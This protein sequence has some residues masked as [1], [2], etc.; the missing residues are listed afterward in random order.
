MANGIDEQT[1]DET[2][3]DHQEI[4]VAEFFEKNKHLLGFE[5]P[6]KSIIT[7]VKE[8][9][10]NSLTWK[11]PFLVKENGETRHEKIGEFVDDLIEDNR[12]NVEVKRD[13]ELEK[14]RVKDNDLESLGFDTQSYDVDFKEVSSVFRHKVNSDIFEV[15]LEGN[16]TVELTDYHSVF[17]LRDGE[18]KSVETSSLTEDDH[19][20]L[21]NTD[22]AEGSIRDINLVEELEQLPKEKTEKIGLHN[23][24]PLI[25]KYRT[26]IEKYVDENYRVQD[27]RKC[28]RLP[29]NLVR[30]L[31]LN[32]SEIE[33]CKLGYRLGSNN[34]PAVLSFD[35]D[36]AELLGIFTAEG[37]VTGD[38]DGHEKVYFSL[39][40]HEKRLISRTEELVRRVFHLEPSTVDAHKT[41]K[42]VTIN[43]KIAGLVFEEIFGMDSKA[44]EKEVPRHLFDVS[45]ELRERFFIGYA[46]G[47]GYPTEKIIE[48]L[49][50]R[51]PLSEIEKK[52]ITVA[53]AS[54]MLSSGMRYLLSSIGIDSTHE[55]AEA[56]KRTVD[57]VETEFGSSNLLH[58]RTGETAYLNRLPAEEI[59][60]SVSAPKL[61][62][63]LDEG[64]QSRVET[65]TTLKLQ[66][67]NSITFKGDGLKIAESD[68]TA[69][70]VKSIEK[71]NYDKKWV[72][73]ISVPG[74]E[75]FMAG[76]HP[77]A[78]H[79]SLDSCEGDEILPEVHVL[80]DEVGDKKCRV[81]IRDNAVG[82]DRETIPKVFG[83]L[84]YGSKFHSLSQ[85]RGQQGIGISASAMYAQLTAGEPVT[86]YSK[87]EGEPCHKFVVR[88]DTEENEPEII[89]DEVIPEDSDQFPGDK[90]YYFEHGTTIEMNIEAQY[91]KGHHSVRNYLKHTAIMNP[92]ARVVLREP[93]GNKIEYPR[94]SNELPEKPQEIKPHL[95]GVE[96]GVVMRMVDNSSARTVS[97]F[98]Q[99]EF[100]RVG[101]TSAQEVCDEADIDDGRRPN[102]LDKDEIEELLNA[103]E[104]VKLQ[105]PPT[106]CLSPIGEDLILEGMEKELNPEFSTAI[107]RKPAVYNGKPYVVECT[108]GETEIILEDGDKKTI[109]QYVE[110]GDQRKVMGLTENG[111]LRPLDVEAKMRIPRDHDIYEVETSSGRRL[112]VTGNNELPVVKQG[113]IEWKRTDE[114]SGDDRLA[115]PASLC[116]ESTELDP[117]NLLAQ[118]DVQVVDREVVEEVTNLLSERYGSLKTAS[119]KIG[120]KCGCFRSFRKEKCTTRPSLKN[121]KEM[122]AHTDKSFE[123]YRQ[124]IGKYSLAERGMVNPKSVKIPELGTDLGYLLGMVES[125]GYLGDEYSVGFTNTSEEL[126]DEFSRL[127]KQ[128]FGVETKEAG[129]DYV[130]VDS[131]TVNRLLGELK[132]RITSSREQILEA[133]LAGFIEGDGCISTRESGEF[134]SLSF[135][136]AE[137][138]KARKVQN[139]LMQIG[140]ASRI[141]ISGKGQEAELN[142]RTIV[143]QKHKHDVMVYSL[144]E[145]QELFERIE[146][147]HPEKESRRRK[148]VDVEK[149]VRSQDRL[150][151]GE[152]LR[153]AREASGLSQTELGLAANSIRSIE[154][155]RAAVRRENLADI[156]EKLSE[157]SHRQQLE[158]MVKSDF[159]SVR[160]ESVEKLDRDDEYVYD[161]K[162]EAGNFVA[163]N[164]IMHNC[165]LA[166]G[167]DIDEEGSFDELRYANKVPLLYKK[168]ACVTTKAIE[169]VSWNRYNISQTGNRPQ[170]ELYILVHIASVWVPFTSEGKEAIAN[171]DPIRKEMK[172]A[173]QEA[174]RK[175]GRYIGRKEKKEIQEK[176]RRQ[177]T[178][179]AE[180]MGPAI[181][182]LAAK[183]DPDEIENQ[184]QKM[185]QEDYNPEQL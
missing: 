82:L 61:E 103:A 5:N 73:D 96:L 100:T 27:F 94:V 45:P 119:G 28:D 60:E 164:L 104:R 33:G 177:L 88:I 91:T 180:E 123:D 40:S 50:E 59:I 26:E 127:M 130:K 107:T 98:L 66:E 163:D 150:N 78:C 169:E 2:G 75:N 148:L 106:D 121:F 71:I 140:I 179:Y 30:E 143:T 128:L 126:L 159:R 161:L 156:C 1:I 110:S 47:D 170:G 153:K 74:H 108:V 154:K 53:T 15:D 77:I 102:T 23:V 81:E 168:S 64:R 35:S 37:S 17:V 105:S 20:V 13:G 118:E 120:I 69:V 178:S 38:R 99:E 117:L 111:K 11:T 109:E 22:W 56:E 14:L 25:G 113:E 162:T 122:V 65:A 16:R 51:K 155:G 12:E 34:I 116:T 133:W 67:E 41:A 166:W 10:D 129:E 58:V 142:G 86:V 165:G 24:K 49:V 85:S 158:K 137:P 160:V 157:S 9:V 149:P 146:L 29:F 136:T 68:L 63:N 139:V 134:K 46:A 184:I 181:A 92:Y 80:I 6:Q 87:Q 97:S 83:K 174:G 55:V 175:L 19:I 167:G 131:K 152:K 4:S 182:E 185:V 176:K 76:D 54:D 32:R 171:Y 95:H 141:S 138:K 90:D 21:P 183:G 132:Q 43:A 173:L 112:K 36:L 70:P 3:E 101:R 42:N 57:G 135:C 151:V 115:E 147:N 93:S 7:V 124:R 72:Y 18:I 44:A 79:N 114:I 125:D 144:N 52:S 31:D 48:A 145:A 84:L 39:G 172:L 89:E 8:A 62:Y